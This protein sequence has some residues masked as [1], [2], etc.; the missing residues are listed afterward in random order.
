VDFLAVYI[1]E[2]HAQDVWPLGNKICIKQPKTMEERIQ[3]AKRFIEEYNFQIPMLVDPME[4]EFDNTFA[5]W[6]ERWWIV[7]NQKI[8][9]IALPTE[10]GY[11]RADLI[12]GIKKILHSVSN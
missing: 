3:V 12:D 8:E 2:A 1:S 9:V 6:P 4:N 10:L 7:M 11:D 5:A